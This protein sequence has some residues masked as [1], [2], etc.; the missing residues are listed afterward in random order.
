MTA[1]ARALI[2]EGK[3]HD[4]ALASHGQ[5]R[6]WIADRGS[7]VVKRHPRAEFHC[8][9]TNAA[10]IAW[11]R[12]NL[13]ALL[14]GY[15]AALDEVYAIAGTAEERLAEVAKLLTE[16][17]DLKLVI[18]QQDREMERMRAAV[19]ALRDNLLTDPRD[20]CS[21][22]LTAILKGAPCTEAAK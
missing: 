1:D 9:P 6:E 5:E 2:A 13:A 22:D 14:E 19:T 12:T 11:L 21:D 10:G 18:E 16:L 7:V 3:R 17:G 20:C 15:S 8:N 4:E